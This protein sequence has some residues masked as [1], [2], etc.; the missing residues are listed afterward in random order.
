MTSTLNTTAW[1]RLIDDDIEWLL[2]QPRTLERD[3]IEHLILW[4]RGV[5]PSELERVEDYHR[6]MNSL[7]RSRMPHGDC[8]SGKRYGGEP[9]ACSACMAH[10]DIDRAIAAYKGRPITCLSQRQE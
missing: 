6:I 10:R 2:K 4:L 5:S 9:L 7:R 8:D 3:H 1:Q